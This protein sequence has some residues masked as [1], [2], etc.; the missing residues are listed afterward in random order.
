[1]GTRPTHAELLDWLAAELMGRGWSLKQLHRLILTS[2]TYRQTNRPRAEAMA[3]DA[4]SQ[5][6]WRFPPRRLEMEPI[7]DSMLAVSGVLDL[8]MGGPGFMVFKDNKNYVRVYDPKEEWGPGE[9]RRMIYAHRVRMTVDGVFGAFDCPD[10]GQPQPVRS[11]STTGIQALNLL[12]S[13]F[14]N[15]QSE[16]LA[17]RAEKEV[18]DDV[19]KQI[20]RVFLLAYSREPND[21]ERA[22]ARETAEKFGLRAVCKAVYNSNEF[23]FLP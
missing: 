9:W 1:M 7:R 22:A 13:T 23:L 19:N 12:N 3:V 17:K 6:L 11:R 20:A 18:G 8:T 21:V 5:L 4:N 14:V 2:N 16:L 15:Q 10:A